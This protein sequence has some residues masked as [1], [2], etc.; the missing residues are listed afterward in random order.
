MPEHEPMAGPSCARVSLPSTPRARAAANRAVALGDIERWVSRIALQKQWVV[1]EWCVLTAPSL[2]VCARVP[3]RPHSRAGDEG[4]NELVIRTARI[5]R[6]MTN[7]FIASTSRTEIFV[8][9]VR[10]VPFVAPTVRGR[11]GARMAAIDRWPR[12]RPTMVPV[13]ANT[14]TSRRGISEP[15]RAR[16]ATCHPCD[17]ERSTPA[18]SR[19]R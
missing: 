6:I 15:S 8:L 19:P 10:F 17:L 11:P 5:E 9:P 7:A 16:S 18:R 1:D 4:G 12:C 13:F 14:T 3:R 2:T